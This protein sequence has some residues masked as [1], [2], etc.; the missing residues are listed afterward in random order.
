MP[1]AQLIDAK[2]GETL[3]DLGWYETANQ[4]RTACG[5]HAE[6]LLVWALSPDGL[7]VAEE[8]DAVYQVEVDPPE[9]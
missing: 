2:T 6:D 4:G 1:R 9:E 3:E 7:W 5:Q 8:E